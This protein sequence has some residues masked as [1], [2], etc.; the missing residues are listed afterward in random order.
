[1]RIRRTPYQRGRALEYRLGAALAGAGAVAQ[2]SAQSRSPVDLW[3]LWRGQVW[4]VQCKILRSVRDAERT[5]LQETSQQA[6]R[7]VL[8]CNES[9]DYVVAA[10]VPGLRKY[11]LRCRHMREPAT[12]GNLKTMMD[13]IL[14]VHGSLHGEAEGQAAPMGDGA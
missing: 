4:L 7:D 9:V 10:Y 11:V 2:R 5:W 12:F 6:I 1:M 13:V 14:L 8:D 3:V